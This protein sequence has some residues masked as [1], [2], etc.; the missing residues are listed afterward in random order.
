MEI[1]MDIL[2]V[3]IDHSKAA[4]EYRESFSFTKHD[5]ARAMNQ[6]MAWYP[7]EIAGCVLISTCNR[8]ELYISTKE[9]EVDPYEILC[10][11]KEIDMNSFVG[12]CTRRKGMDVVEHLLELA[13]GL[14]SMVFGEDQIITQVKDALANARDT[15]ATDIVLEKLFQTAITAAKKVKASVHL[16][17][18]NSSVVENMITV[19]QQE[20]DTISG[21][22][23]LVIGNGE[24][25][26]L[27]AMRLLQAGAKVTVTLRQYKS[28]EIDVPLG[29]NCIDYQER[30]DNLADMNVIV[31]ATTSPHHTIRYEE[32]YPLFADGK[33]RVLVDMAV[34]RDISLRLAELEHI[35]LYNIDSLGGISTNTVNNQ[36]VAIA[37]EILEE[38]QQE[39][40]KW[41]LFREYIPL[42][43]SVGRTSALSVIDRIDKQTKK[44]IVDDN[45]VTELE[46]LLKV[47]TN[48]VV[49]NL[50]YGLKE[51]LDQDK[52][53]VCLEA[54]EKSSRKNSNE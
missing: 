7:E 42:I 3:G 40:R 39:F 5:A 6:I 2:M 14:K 21:I 51:N 25:G 18:V 36:S 41:Y 53:E 4:I 1:E 45:T 32:A 31:S 38:Y 35:K 33:K 28:R 37:M 24:I 15:E 10:R 20:F 48:R 47:A 17:A 43:Q 26:R 23:C 29:V 8:T 50:L 46:K 13:C 49:T 34:P 11:V 54:I 52:W 30:Y 44:L 16:T 12:M 19:L 27:A 9:E 22:P